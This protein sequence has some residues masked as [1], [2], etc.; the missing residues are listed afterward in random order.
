MYASHRQQSTWVL[1]ERGWHKSTHV[2]NQIKQIL[3]ARFLVSRPGS[4]A[5]TSLCTT[6]LFI[7]ASPSELSFSRP[8]GARLECLIASSEASPAPPIS[9]GRLTALVGIG[10]G[11]IQMSSHWSANLQ[12]NPLRCN[13]GSSEGPWNGS[14]EQHPPGKRAC[15]VRETRTRR[16]P[17]VDSG[18]PQAR[19]PS[20]ASSESDFSQRCLWPVRIGIRLGGRGLPRNNY[21]C[22]SWL[23]A[24]ICERVHQKKRWNAKLGFRGRSWWI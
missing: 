1:V 22:Y 2:C 14:K 10:I 17:S 21:P 5:A 24:T 15:G 23:T 9:P 4:S 20:G 8:I 7:S 18:G 6:P 3:T 16:T 12:V 19:S 13:Q 11:L